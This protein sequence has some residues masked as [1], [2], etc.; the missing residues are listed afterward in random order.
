MGFLDDIKKNV[1][2]V[3]HRPHDQQQAQAEAPVDAAPAE[4][5]VD[6]AP[7]DAPVDAAPAE[8]PAAE[9]PVAEA[10][11]AP[12]AEAPREVVVES[13]DTPS[14]IAA[15]FGVDLNALIAANADTVPN[16]DLIYPGQVLRLP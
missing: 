9:V 11:E 3:L 10:P 6:T 13:G 8:A 16:P 14:G 7:V 15:Q 12:V 5:S 2:N 4:A 1:E